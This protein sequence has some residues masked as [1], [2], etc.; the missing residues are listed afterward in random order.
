MVASAPF[1]PVQLPHPRETP[2]SQAHKFPFAS[3]CAGSF[4]TICTHFYY[5]PVCVWHHES[6]AP[7][8]NIGAHGR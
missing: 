6:G 5:C 2:Q 1:N 3:L 4:L 8:A 7:L